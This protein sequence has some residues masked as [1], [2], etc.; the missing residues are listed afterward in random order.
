LVI[1]ERLLFFHVDA[2]FLSVTIFAPINFNIHRNE[3]AFD[4]K[5]HA[6]IVH[7]LVIYTS[8]KQRYP[9]YSKTYVYAIILFYLSL[10][11]DAGFKEAIHRK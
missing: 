5:K 3:W 1:S 6:L 10:F 9:Y 2:V 4:A 8:E 7:I 11:D